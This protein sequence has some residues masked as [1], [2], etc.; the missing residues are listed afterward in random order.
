MAI[1]ITKHLEKLAKRSQAVQKQYYPSLYEKKFSIACLED[2]FQEDTK[3]TKMP[4]LVHKYPH[5][6]LILLTGSCAAYCRFC[7]RRR[8]TL[9]GAQYKLSRKEIANIAKYLRD[10]NTVNEIII[11]GGDPLTCI[12]EILLLIKLA[13]KIKNI[14]IIRIHTRMPVAD[15]QNIPEKLFSALKKIKN[16]SIY[17]LVHFEHPDEITPQTLKAL[18]KFRESGAILLSQSVFLKGINDSYKTLFELFNRLSEI[19]VIAYMIG[20]C[21]KVKGVEHFIVPIEKEIEI[22]TELRKNISGIAFPN[23]VID[24]PEG[25]GKIIVPGNFWDFD[26]KKFRDF[27]GKEIGMY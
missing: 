7:T 6:V 22:M 21:D 26:R 16:K 5:R 1:K 15:P 9:N 10:N 24:A 19:G 14:K 13:E 4:G 12:P 3:Y 11:S 27:H 2:P 23:H 18:R 17:V 20:H 25:C 8:H